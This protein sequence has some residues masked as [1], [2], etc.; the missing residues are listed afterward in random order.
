MNRSLSLFALFL[1]FSTPGCMATGLLVKATSDT[2]SYDVELAGWRAPDGDRP[3]LLKLRQSS[4]GEGRVVRLE[5]WPEAHTILSPAYRPEIRVVPRDADPRTCGG[6]GIIGFNLAADA[7]VVRQ[8]E[9]FLKEA[10]G[11]RSLGVLPPLERSWLREHLWEG[12]T[13]TLMPVTVAVD[14]AL[15][16]VEVL[17]QLAYWFT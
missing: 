11:W 13:I 2:Q 14:T 16:P 4:W 3:G 6:I 10:Q 1:V 7:D 5:W 8:K 17:I 15:F 12:V 9:V